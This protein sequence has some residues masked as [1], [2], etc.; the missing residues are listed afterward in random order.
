MSR[1][2]SSDLLYRNTSLNGLPERFSGR[3]GAVIEVKQEPVSKTAYQ[4]RLEKGEA[5]EDED[6][7]AEE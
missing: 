4:E 6:E 2:M 3:D 7:E 1:G 5:S